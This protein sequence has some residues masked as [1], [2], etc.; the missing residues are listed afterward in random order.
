MVA[1]SVI[2]SKLENICNFLYRTKLDN[3]PLTIKATAQVPLNLGPVLCVGIRQS[4]GY[5]GATAPA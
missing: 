5:G 3:T 2:M 4:G 1:S